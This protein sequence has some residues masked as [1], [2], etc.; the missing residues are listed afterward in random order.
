MDILNNNLV[1]FLTRSSGHNYE[2]ETLKEK[3][4]LFYYQPQTT[5]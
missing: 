4:N 3:L 5:P 2:R 1:K